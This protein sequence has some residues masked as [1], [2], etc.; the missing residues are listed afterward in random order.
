MATLVTPPL[1]PSVSAASS[2]PAP[3]LAQSSPRPPSVQ[4]QLR[5]RA[6]AKRTRTPD[7]SEQLE[8]T[9]CSSGLRR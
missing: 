7:T 8:D 9:Q 1:S 2:A 5:L 6:A 4:N 3:Q